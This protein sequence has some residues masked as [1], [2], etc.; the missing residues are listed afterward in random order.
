M[1]VSR[2]QFE[3]ASAK[4]RYVVES[5]EGFGDVR[6]QSLTHAERTAITDAAKNGEDTFVG[7]L[8]ACVVDEHDNTI[9]SE[10]DRSWLTKLDLQVATA[11]DQAMSRH[12]YGHSLQKKT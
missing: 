5:I 6:L 10:D 2:A 4:R 8:I 7:F 3:E 12:V 1:A 9:F 11:L